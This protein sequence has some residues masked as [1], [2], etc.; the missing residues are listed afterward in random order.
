MPEKRRFGNEQYKR[1]AVKK[2]LE[3]EVDED[4]LYSI[5]TTLQEKENNKKQID[6]SY[7]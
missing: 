1:L 7:V 6:P 3:G 2:Y 5:L 4:T